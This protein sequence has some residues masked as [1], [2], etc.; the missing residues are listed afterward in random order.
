MNKGINSLIPGFATR[1]LIQYA[2]NT[3]QAFG[4]GP[5]PGTAAKSVPQETFWVG[6]VEITPFRGMRVKYAKGPKHALHEY[7]EPAECPWA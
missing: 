5:K 4:L 1:L 2:M 6:G 7:G 3:W